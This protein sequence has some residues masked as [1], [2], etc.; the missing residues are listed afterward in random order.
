ME[1]V[2]WFRLVLVPVESTALAVPSDGV[3]SW[4]VLPD[5]VSDEVA[6]WLVELVVPPDDPSVVDDGG[7]FES[8]VLVVL[9]A[10]VVVLLDGL[11]VATEAKAVGGPPALV[12]EPPRA[13]GPGPPPA[14]A[15]P[16]PVPALP[17]VPEPSVREPAVLVV[18]LTDVARVT[19]PR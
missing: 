11:A 10:D 4:L 14:P 6:L 5:V 1:S 16:P 12:E 15:V 19:S 3:D 18:Q 7:V 13:A 17:A 2:A 8:D 9:L